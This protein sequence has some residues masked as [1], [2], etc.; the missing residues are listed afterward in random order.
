MHSTLLK[1][2]AANDTASRCPRAAQWSAIRGRLASINVSAIGIAGS[3]NLT[4]AVASGSIGSAAVT[5]TFNLYRALTEMA[6]SYVRRGGVRW[7]G[8]LRARA[9]RLIVFAAGS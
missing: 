8:E 4:L 9:I 5:L 3:G 1:P 7:F 6:A 2:S